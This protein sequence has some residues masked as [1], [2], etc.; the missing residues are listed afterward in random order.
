VER[1]GPVPRRD[2]RGVGALLVGTALLLAVA[3]PLPAAIPEPAAGGHPGR[4]I[5]APWGRLFVETEG[6]GPPLLLL[7]DG[8]G[9]DHA[10]FHPYLSSLAPDRTLVY[11]D[12]RGCGRSDAAPPEGGTLEGM[13]ADVDTVRRALG[14]ERLDL[15]A[16]GTGSAVAVLYAV[17]HPERVGRIVLVGPSLH[18][19]S[20]ITSSRLTALMTP[21]MRAAVDAARR[22]RYLS[23]DGRLKERLRIV[24]PLLF[25]RLTDR[26]F[27]R[28]FVE[29]ITVAAG[30]LRGT[31]EE[32][33]DLA[34][35]LARLGA[36]LLILA[37]RYDP[38]ASVR[39]AEAVRD[40]VRGAR[41]QVMEESGTF[42]FVEQPVDFVKAVRAFLSGG[43]STGGAAG[44]G[45]GI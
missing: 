32:S 26:G 13:V 14:Y 34:N 10:Y 16:H 43:E 35:P 4:M 20:L 25:H 44:A 28:A 29:P 37:G 18:P 31:A 30:T 38:L 41:L 11:L 27:H 22:N 33:P 5:T 39:E 45:G 36:P 15:L 2:G 23:E 8:P 42:P 17:G 24:T 21:E 19:E 12:P 6:S 40:A 7:P 3:T 1:R 9:L